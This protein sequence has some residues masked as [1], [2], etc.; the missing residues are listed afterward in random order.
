MVGSALHGQLLADGHEII[1]QSRSVHSDSPKTR[2]IRHELTSDSWE[3]LA[4][5]DIDVVYHL[6]GQTSVY[7]ARQDPIDDLF[8]N[9][10]ALLRLLEHF[11]KQPHPPFIV[12]ASTVTVTGLTERLPIDESAID[13]PITFY[14]LSKLSAEMYLDQ[15]VREGWIRGCS[16]RFANVFGRSLPGQQA[17]RGVI[18]KILKR[19]LAGQPLTVFGAGDYLR[20]YIFID[21]IVSALIL[22]PRHSEQTS[23]RRFVLGTGQALT[24]KQAFAK[25]AA[26]VNA[27][28]GINVEVVHIEPPAG[29]SAIEYRNAVID[30]SAFSQVTGWRPQYNFDSGLEQACQSLFGQAAGRRS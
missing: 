23:G 5:P 27:A 18:D 15:Y 21:D 10:A 28:T 2:W 6:A 8:A 14:D 1:C 24:V 30:S 4:L 25:I 16:L 12:L 22:A 26:R 3:G 20:D 29:L 13:R 9:V 11:R 17:D 7:Q 19:A